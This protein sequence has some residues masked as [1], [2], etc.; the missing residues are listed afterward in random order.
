MKGW[1]CPGECSQAGREDR[2]CYH[3]TQFIVSQSLYSEAG[4]YSYY[5]INH[6]YSSED[7]SIISVVVSITG[8]SRVLM[9]FLSHCWHRP[10]RHPAPAEIS[11]ENMIHRSPLTLRSYIR[12]SRA[13]DQNVLCRQVLSL[14][15]LCKHFRDLGS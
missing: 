9:I 13:E 8:V 5:C 11:G 2:R 4:Y 6:Y 3:W 12:E 7:D 15:K 14:I 10:H 1:Q